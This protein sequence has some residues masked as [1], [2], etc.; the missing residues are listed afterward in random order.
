MSKPAT[1]QGERTHRRQPA[2]RALDVRRL[3]ELDVRRAVP[4]PVDAEA[5]ERDEVLLALAAREL[6]REDRV[7]D[8]A[9]DDAA[10]CVR[11]YA[12]GQPRVERTWGER[13]RGARLHVKR[14]MVGRWEDGQR[15]GKWKG[16]GGERK[17]KRVKREERERARTRK[18]RLLR[19]MALQHEALARVRDEVRGDR[20]V[21]RHLLDDEV[22]LPAVELVRPV[23][24]E[25]PAR[26][27]LSATDYQPPPAYVRRK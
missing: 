14:E 5:R 22:R 8:L 17:R 16:T 7:A 18:A 23:P 1:Q 20:R 4:Q 12:R 19:G 24:V 2:R 10:A 11:I 25:Q 6:D 3:G 9:H 13:Y 27:F 15:G 26:A 21:V